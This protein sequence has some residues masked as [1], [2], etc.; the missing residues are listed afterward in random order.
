MPSC[1]EQVNGEAQKKAEEI[2]AEVAIALTLSQLHPETGNLSSVAGSAA[3][4]LRY[5]LRLVACIP[6]Q[7]CQPGAPEGQSATGGFSRRGLQSLDHCLQGDEI[8]YPSNIYS[9]SDAIT[10]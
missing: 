4:P 5:L 1:N 9:T 2:T 6:A 3:L 10:L 8:A 7:I